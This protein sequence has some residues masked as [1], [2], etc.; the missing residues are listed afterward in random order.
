MSAHAGAKGEFPHAGLLCWS[1]VA[2][3]ILHVLV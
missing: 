1:R 3:V 2:A